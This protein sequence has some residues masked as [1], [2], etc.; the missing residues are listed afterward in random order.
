MFIVAGDK[1]SPSTFPSACTFSNKGENTLNNKD[2]FRPAS[3]P[4]LGSLD[5]LA[6]ML[7]FFYKPLLFR[8]KSYIEAGGGVVCG[9]G[10]TTG[11]LK[12]TDGNK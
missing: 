11:L 4:H 10:G 5:Y 9:G 8:E 12:C 1:N 7:I 3:H 2:A 6:G